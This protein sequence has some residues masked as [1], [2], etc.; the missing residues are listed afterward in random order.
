MRKQYD[1]TP[2]PGSTAARVEGAPEGTTTEK[3]A[4]NKQL[5]FLGDLI[6]ARE[7]A[8]EARDQLSRRIEVQSQ[9][10]EEHG[11]CA[12]PLAAAGLTMSRARDFITRLLE[13]PKR[14]R[15]LPRAAAK[16]DI[17][18]E[19]HYT[20]PGPDDL[21][22]GHYAIKNPE[23][24][25]RFYRV[26]RGT[27]NTAVVWLYIEHGPSDSQIPFASPEFKAILA[28]I[29]EDPLTAARTYGA[30]I[31]SCGRCSKRLTNRVSRLLN[32][33][34]V[35]GGHMCDPEVWADLKRRAREALERAGLDPDQDVEDTDD[36]DRI[37]AEAG[38]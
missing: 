25:L 31:G 32:I 33:G 7:I 15:E 9:L 19:H 11:D 37:R 23:Q 5:T 8:E 21:P 2:P 28:K 35:C 10:N 3:G 26:K 36:L 18:G 13:K 29:A 34:P 1:L 17:I 14:V 20:P 38:L 6:E 12:P 30:H 27:R 22:A 16:R 4:S 24:Q